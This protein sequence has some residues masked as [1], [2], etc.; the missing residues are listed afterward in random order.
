MLARKNRK[1]ISIFLS[2]VEERIGTSGQITYPLLVI[3]KINIPLKGEI[4]HSMEA[5][6]KLA[7]T[8]FLEDFPLK[9]NR[10]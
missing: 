9:Q 8:N 10:G 2:C 7:V 4:T 1:E 6:A 3:Y 5:K